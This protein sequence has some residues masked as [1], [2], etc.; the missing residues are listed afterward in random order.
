MT[1]EEWQQVKAL[2]DLALERP[3][4][5]RLSFVVQAH[6]DDDEMRHEVEALIRLATSGG[7]VLDAPVWTGAS[8]APSMPAVIGRYR[9]L[10]L[11][12]EGGMG[13]V[14]KA[15]QDRPRRIVALKV[16]KPGLTTAEMRKRFERESD[17]LAR[18]QHPGI[19]QI[20]EVGTAESPVGPLPYFAM[21]L[22]DGTTLHEYAAS[23]RLGTRERLQLMAR[24]CD[25]IEH[26][27]QRGIIHRDLK[28]ANILLDESGQPKILDFGVARV[29][30]S[31]AHVTRQTDIG[32]LVGTLAYMSPEQVLADP[33]ALDTRSDVYALGV[34]LYELLASR[35]P[36][37]L[38]TKL[39]EAARTIQ[40]QDPARLSSVSREYRGDIETIV[41]K[42]LEKDKARR[43][44]S[45]AAL[46]EDIR[47][48]LAD[49]PIMARPPSA[50]YQIAKFTRRHKAL[51][52]SS[53]AVFLAL[54]AGTVISTREALRANNE[55]AIATAVSDFLRNDVLAQASAQ[56][57][58]RPDTKADPD[59]KVRTA[60]DRA[61]ARIGSKF[62]G[63]P[64]VE[65]SIRQTIGIAYQDLG[66]YPEARKQIERALDLRRR[67]L[68]DNDPA[69]LD[70]ETDIG[71]SYKLEGK[72]AES[73]REY[74]RAL[75]G[76]RRAY[77]DETAPVMKATIAL[78]DVYQVQARYPQAEALLS[79]VIDVQRRRAP[80]DDRD[81]ADT[82]A[83]LGFLYLNQGK[84]PQAAARYEEALASQR[85]VHGPD[86]PNTIASMNG[87]GLTYRGLGR[88]SEAEAMFEQALD[89]QRRAPGPDHPDTLVTTN[90]LAL[91][92]TNDGRY[93]DAQPLYE[94]ILEVRRRVLGPDH[95][96]TLLAMNNLGNLYSEGGRYAE[97]EPLLASTL[98]G[99]QRVLGREHPNTLN[100][101]T[102]I[103]QLYYREGRWPESDKL[104][105]DIL[106]A[107][108][109]VLGNDHP[110]TQ[111]T[112]NHMGLLYTR[113]GKWKEAQALL[114][115][116]REFWRKAFGPEHAQTLTSI[117]LLGDLALRRG[118]VGEAQSLL[119]SAYEARQR[120]LGKEHP[121]TL[122]SAVNVAR[123]YMTL[124]RRS[125]AEALLTAT[126][127]TQRR[128]FGDEHPDTIATAELLRR[129]AGGQSSARAQR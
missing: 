7:G 54:A 45:A 1:P 89:G 129:V 23:H 108:R 19:A 91:A 62:S 29:T 87:L 65:A 78:A 4:E 113:M 114:T 115:S 37:A 98:S 96:D 50:S 3:P 72:Y 44:P 40:D 128:L 52:A 122:R 66:L 103:A 22:I 39:I 48:Y 75:E 64:A 10:G 33:L 124:R 79:Q 88:Q 101:M 60:L 109:R 77:G 125:E 105:T 58:A 111:L 47:R 14:Y 34:I 31:D 107:R 121:D 85:R 20:Y 84:Y 21:E 36:Y 53:L 127:A 119:T 94:H 30:D 110:S 63:Q 35:L 11:V 71:R 49:Q 118:D 24:I 55:A 126:L 61:A 12:G 57:Q 28:P 104:Y 97:A 38:S 112:L 70:T 90:N 17:A 16:I 42:A 106:A 6:P 69:T 46:A 15:E 9:V 27:H 67:T 74:E 116:T 120:V 2:C 73:A 59:L 56:S 13:A 32:Q 86:H 123:L 76:L 82:V 18:L 80:L 100:T 26:A 41:A 83:N 117:D 93:R 81:A 8:S 102:N 5:D 68:G 43:Y 95:P 25:A 99:R 92:Y 51:V